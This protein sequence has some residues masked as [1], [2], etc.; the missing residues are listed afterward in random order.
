[1]LASIQFIISKLLKQQVLLTQ[2]HVSKI[3]KYTKHPFY[4][5]SV[6]QWCASVDAQCNH[7]ISY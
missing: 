3:N 4:S 5:K 7:R 6:I 1:M 2:I